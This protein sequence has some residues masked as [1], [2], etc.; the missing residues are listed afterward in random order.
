M[1]GTAHPL[2]VP[3]GG[4]DG[5]QGSAPPQDHG[6]RPG[7]EGVRQ[8]VGVRRNVPAHGFHHAHAVH[9]HVQRLGLGAALGV[10]VGLDGPLLGGVGGQAVHR[11]GGEG[12]QLALPQEG[13]GPSDLP[14]R[15]AHSLGQA[16]FGQPHGAKNC[17]CQRDQ[18]NRH[19]QNHDH[20]H[21]RRTRRNTMDAQFYR[22]PNPYKALVKQEGTP[23]AQ[24]KQPAKT[25]TQ[26]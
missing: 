7:P 2:G 6:Q 10:V 13:G 5:G 3:P 12:H 14:V 9:Q 26:Q 8:L 11:L 23:K 25:E 17:R 22:I 16:D 21:L 4:N 20:Q 18:R 24:R 15:E 19:I 1:V